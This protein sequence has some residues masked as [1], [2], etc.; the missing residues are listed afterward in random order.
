MSDLHRKGVK[1]DSG[2]ILAGVLADFAKALESVATVGTYGAAKYTRGGW[3]SVPDGQQ[4][5]TDALWRHLLASSY[6]EV[7][8]ESGIPHLHH[9]LWNLIAVVELKSKT[10][11][12]L[13][14]ED[15]KD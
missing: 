8:P 9:A 7:D 12:R 5:Y 15:C 1:D 13:W 11:S 10:A 3:I 2:K 6:E 4:R 14:Q